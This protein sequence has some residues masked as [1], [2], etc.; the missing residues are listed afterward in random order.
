M[1]LEEE[2]E[3]GLTETALVTTTYRTTSAL[4]VAF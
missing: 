2:E 3:E 1:G 4:G